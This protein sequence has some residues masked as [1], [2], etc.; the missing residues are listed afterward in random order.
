MSLAWWHGIGGE[1]ANRRPAGSPTISGAAIVGEELTT[2][3]SGISDSD[4][5]TNPNWRY[6]WF[7]SNTRG[8]SE[9]EISGATSSTY[10]IVAADVGMSLFVRVTF[11]DDGGNTHTLDSARTRPAIQATQTVVGTDASVLV[12][13]TSVLF[14]QLT[15]DVPLFNSWFVGGVAPASFTCSLTPTG[16]VDLQFGPASS[17]HLVGPNLVSALLAALSITIAQGSRSVTIVGVQDNTGDPYNWLPSNAAEVEA[18]RA[19][20]VNGQPGTVTLSY[21]PP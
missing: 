11:T 12:L 13:Q 2:S 7:R 20:V 5:L 14:N 9:V 19:R 6:Q 15:L 17:E 1:I 21:T 10:T 16:N 3:I 8:T 4:G 18:F